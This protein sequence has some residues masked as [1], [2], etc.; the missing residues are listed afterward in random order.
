MRTLKHAAVQLFIV[1]TL[2]TVLLGLS[3]CVVRDLR[4]DLESARER[5]GYLKAKITGPSIKSHAVVGLFK[6]D[7][8]SMS[9]VNVRTVEVG[10]TFYFLVPD[11]NY[12]LFAFADDNHD[13]IYQPGEPAVRVEN[14]LINRLK[15]FES[16]SRVE[17]EAMVEQKFLL[18]SSVVLDQQ[19]DFSVEALRERS[20]VV[21]NFL[22]VVDWGDDRFSDANI[23]RGMWEPSAF[24]DQVG[25]GLYSLKE[26]D[27]SQKSI[28]LVHGINGSPRDFRALV[29][30]LPLGYQA[31]L[32]HYPSGFSLE[33][34]AYMLTDALE[35]LLR[36][37]DIPDLDVIAH[38]MGGLVSQGMLYQLEEGL[39]MRIENFITLATPFAG[40]AAA[41]L[42]IKWAP[43]VAP[44]WWA[45]APNS[46]YLQKISTVDLSSGPN[47][48]LIFSFS[49]Q[50]G[51]DSKGDDG[52][53]SVKSQ[54]AYPAQ[55][56][57]TG[58]YGIAD[59]HNGVIGNACTVA[60]LEDILA[61]G[62]SKVPFPGC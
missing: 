37:Y 62:S 2:A 35:E 13:F 49:R 52:V 45:M 51:G 4:K 7:G 11:A 15:D 23:R 30:Q 41:G 56:N 5:Y 61:D 57:V 27:P 14:P 19:L 31:L 24:Q 3:S 34:S 6:R 59:D 60:L 46:R 8:D 38:S 44:V 33:H 20:N 43:T 10:E 58:M 47:H 39:R 32:F 25:Y 17:Y 26:F 28:L 48:H 21:A 55:R 9:I 1:T 53:V 22:G 42:G 40:H 54:L 16:K 50:A 36:R 29:E 18:S 12:T